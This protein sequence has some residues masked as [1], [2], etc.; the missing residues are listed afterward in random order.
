MEGLEFMDFDML[1][2]INKRVI[3]AMHKSTNGGASGIQNCSAAQEMMIILSSTFEKENSSDDEGKFLMAKIVESHTDD[4][5][6]SV[7]TLDVDLPHADKD[8]KSEW[9]DTSA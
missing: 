2:V 8:L 5:Y 9:D 6:D 7:G 3:A 4:P 1:D